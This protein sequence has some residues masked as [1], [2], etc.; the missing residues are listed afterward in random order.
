MTDSVHPQST[1][2]WVKV[3]GMLQQNW[4]LI[5][6]EPAGRIRV[7]FITDT[8]GIFDEIGFESAGH[9]QAA[10]TRNGF[11]RLSDNTDL[12]SI[13]RPPS[14][15]FHRTTHPNGPIYSSGRYWQS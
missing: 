15:P 6:N 2:F 8:S 4:A 13:L 9:A 1:D 11:R 12:Q 14:A 3:V 5:E 7:H 10:L